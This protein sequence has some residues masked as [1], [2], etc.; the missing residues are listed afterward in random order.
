MTKSPV[1]GSGSNAGLRAVLWLDAAAMAGG[2][3]PRA[4]VAAVRVLIHPRWRAVLMWRVAQ[5][6]VGRR[7]GRL[8]ALWLTGRILRGCGAELMPTSRIGPGLC[9]VHTTGLVVGAEV[10]AGSRLTLHQGVTLGD[11]Y[12]G[13]GQPSLGDDVV[14]GAGATVLGPVALGDGCRIAANAVVLHDVPAG[15]LAVGVPWRGPSGRTA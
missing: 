4:A 8:P 15:T 5:W 2:Q 1:E 10:I 3:R 6:S 9:L 14:I 11:R 12:P 13:G 7:G